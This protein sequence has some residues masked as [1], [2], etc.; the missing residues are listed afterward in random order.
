MKEACI[1]KIQEVVAGFQSV[2][3][4]AS[5]LSFSFTPFSVSILNTV[6]FISHLPTSVF[7]IRKWEL[8]NSDVKLLRTRLFEIIRIQR[9]L[10]ILLLLLE[11]DYRDYAFYI[12]TI[13]YDGFGFT[14]FSVANVG[15]SKLLR[16]E[17]LGRHLSIFL[18]LPEC[19]YRYDVC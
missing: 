4:F 5:T 3:P 16:L 1:K 13:I 7:T 12:T 17:N 8:I 10:S 15:F 11:R 18:L 6:F 14:R 2:R 19:D 9:G